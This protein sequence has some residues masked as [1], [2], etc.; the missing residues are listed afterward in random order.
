MVGAAED[1]EADVHALL[2]VGG[3]GGISI[4]VLMGDNWPVSGRRDV[5][6][7]DAEIE[8]DMETAEP[9]DMASIH[10]GDCGKA[11]SW[12]SSEAIL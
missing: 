9:V 8:A 5:P 11:I 2:S 6:A 10:G 12:L 3:P 4:P 1:P 7:D